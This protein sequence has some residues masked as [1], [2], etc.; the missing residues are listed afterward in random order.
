[1]RR[2]WDGSVQ[3]SNT[4]LASNQVKDHGIYRCIVTK[5]YFADDSSNIS[6]NA[7]NPEVLYDVVVLGG[8]KGGQT[9][10]NARMSYGQGGNTSF[11]ETILTPST[12][13]L[14]TTT[15]SKQDGDVVYVVFN[16]GNPDY[17]LIVGV[18]KGLKQDNAAT[19]AQSP[20]KIEQYNGIQQEVNNKGEHIF[21]QFGGKLD[22]N[23]AFQANTTPQYT[24]TIT[25]D[26]KVVETHSAGLS[27]SIDGKNDLIEIFTSGGADLKVDGKNNAVGIL[28]QGGTSVKVDG[29]GNMITISAGSTEIVVDGASGKISL[30]GGIVEL[31]SSVSD[32]VTMFSALSQAYNAHTHMV[33]QAP[34]GVLPS[35]PPML[36][37][38][39]SVGSATVKVQS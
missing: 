25:A 1:M 30:K 23:N 34:A 31:G 21:T 32:F 10:N 16:Q 36:P 12:Q 15:L 6:K 8:F 20:R 35:M 9:I 28:T 24:R 11:Q 5:V 38:L 29:K 13:S 39:Q 22:S 26:G 27:V 7:Q 17:P 3:S 4:P 33:P 2:R 18:A 19:A 14:T 37:L